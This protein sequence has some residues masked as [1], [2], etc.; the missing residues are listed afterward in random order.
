M[1][2]KMIFFPIEL[3]PRI[4]RKGRRGRE[5]KS[6]LRTFGVSPGRGGEGGSVLER[7]IGG[8][9]PSLENPPDR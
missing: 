2:F 1:I 9:H 4:L 6:I 7:E 5:K 3:S 8:R